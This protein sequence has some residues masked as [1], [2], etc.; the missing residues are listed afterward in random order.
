MKKAKDEK[1]I[2]E[3]PSLK[4]IHQ[5]RRDRQRERGG[6]AI[7][8]GSRMESERLAKKYGLKLARTTAVA[9]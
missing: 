5:I 7:H 1:E 4:W 2:W 8:P 9:R 6:R 3:T